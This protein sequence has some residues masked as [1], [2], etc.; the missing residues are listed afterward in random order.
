MR[1][2]THGLKYIDMCIF[3]IYIHIYT[4][5]YIYMCIYIYIHIYIY[6]WKRGER[7][8]NLP[9]NENQQNG[10]YDYFGKEEKKI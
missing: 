6:I 1:K 5:I 4:Y 7:D 3:Y 10:D 2:K 9:R 8:K